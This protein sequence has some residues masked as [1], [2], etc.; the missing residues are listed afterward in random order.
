MPRDARWL[1]QFTPRNI[2]L[3]VAG[4]LADTAI[5]FF[6]ILGDGTR[7]GHLGRILLV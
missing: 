2:P 6:A 4:R 3:V 1:G 7:F 5:S